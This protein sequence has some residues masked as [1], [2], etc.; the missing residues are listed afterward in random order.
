M[1]KKG[2]L[3]IAEAFLAIMLI[4]GFLLYMT[5]V[6]GK[7]DRST[8]FY[9]LERQ[10]LSEIASNPALRQQILDNNKAGSEEY[11]RRRIP[12]YLNF[13]I[14][15]CEIDKICAKTDYIEQDVYADDTIISSTLTKYSPKKLKIFIWEK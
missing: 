6:S 13:E 9:G 15:I 3:R 10:I 7:K 4:A 12:S 11:A 8:E 5:T 1:N 2:W 14:K